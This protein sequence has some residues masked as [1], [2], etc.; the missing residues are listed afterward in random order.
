MPFLQISYSTC[1]FKKESTVAQSG[2]GRLWL[3]PKWFLT[4]EDSDT[5]LNTNLAPGNQER[6]WWQLWALCATQQPSSFR[7]R[8]SRL[9]CS[10]VWGV[11][12]PRTAGLV[13]LLWRLA[14]SSLIPWRFLWFTHT[15]CWWISEVLVT[16]FALIFTAVPWENLKFFF[17]F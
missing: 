11:T 1:Y 9:A 4:Q 3:K 17:F 8:K 10:P 5:N 12:S 15:S 6:L 14:W 16:L 7:N 2:P 13:P